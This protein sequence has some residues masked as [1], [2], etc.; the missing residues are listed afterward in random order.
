VRALV[1]ASASAALASAFAGPA[2]SG[3]AS[4]LRGV[5]MRGPTSPI[6]RVGDP[7]EEPARGLLLQFRRDGRIVKQVRTSR[8]GW[9]RV[10]L[11][12]GRYAVTTPGVR[13]TA[14]LQPQL[15]SVRRGRVLRRDF[16]LDTGIQ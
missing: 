3:T 11:R 10:L 12:R 13:P 6:C 15:V 16:H 7:C 4:G 8:T 2:A 9:Y 14:R 1:I 5:V